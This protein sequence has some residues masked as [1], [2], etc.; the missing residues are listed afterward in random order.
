MAM[1]VGSIVAKFR[2]ELEAE[3]DAA[4]ERANTV[5]VAPIQDAIPVGA[6]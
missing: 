2:E 1:P 3:I 5:P 6:H 4:R